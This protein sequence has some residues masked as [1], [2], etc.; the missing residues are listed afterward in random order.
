V[1]P[2]ELRVAA[3]RI[4]GHGTFALA[5]IPSGSIVVEL[6]DPAELGP[7]NHS[8]DPNLGWADDHSLRA[9]RDIAADEE[10]TVDYATGVLDPSFVMMCHCETYRCRQVI[11]GT[12]WQIPQLQRRYAGWF[13]P[14]IQRRIDAATAPGH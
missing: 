5:P 1:P 10:L 8:C 7:V 6:G 2:A 14:A 9:V 12:D 4:A 11:E 13:A 3:S